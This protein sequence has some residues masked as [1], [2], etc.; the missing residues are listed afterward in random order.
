MSANTII[1][2][3]IVIILVVGA[4]TYMIRGMRKMRKSGGK[5][6]C[7]CSL[8]DSCNDFNKKK[9]HNSVNR[10]DKGEG[11]CPK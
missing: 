1:Q 2:Y 7:G 5:S 9:R 10:K 3:A 8:A 4:V 11:C 6:C